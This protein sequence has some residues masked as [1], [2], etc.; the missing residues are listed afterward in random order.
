MAY[1][2]LR[3]AYP[4]V[5]AKSLLSMSVCTHLRLGGV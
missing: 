2:V 1:G 4:F 3:M 5:A